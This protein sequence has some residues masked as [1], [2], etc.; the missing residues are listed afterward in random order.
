MEEWALV[1]GV[2]P[3]V[4]TGSAVAPAVEEVAVALERAW[5][6]LEG[7]LARFADPLPTGVD[8]GGWDVRH[9]LS[10]LVGAWQRVPVH[11]GFFLGDGAAAEVPIQLHHSY[12]LPEW[13]T[14]PLASFVLALEAAYE[15]NKR[16][17]R[18]LDPAA[19]DRRRR[20]PLGELTLRELLLTGYDRHIAGLHVPQ[21]EA[22]LVR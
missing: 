6:R 12:W 20:T 21:L 2:L 19:L 8:A 17:L 3:E 18:R 4:E 1:I 9:L 10:H 14:A 22:F 15:G 13:Q 5:R 11:A 16:L 7:V